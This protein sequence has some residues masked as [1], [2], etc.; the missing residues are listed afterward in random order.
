[1]S[2]MLLQKLLSRTGKQI[3]QESLEALYLKTGLDAT[4]PIAIRG[5]IT[6]RC[7]YRCRYCNFWRQESY[8]EEMTIEEWQNALLSLKSFIGSY[9]IQFSGGEPFIKPGFVDLLEFCHREKIGWGVIT[10]GSAFNRRTVER[11]VAAGPTNIDISVDA[12]TPDIHDFVRGVPG[13]LDRITR[14]IELLRSQRQQQDLDFPIRLKPTV[15]RLNFR[16]L[17]QLVEWAQQVGASTIDFSPVRTLLH[18]SEI[19]TELWLN[20]RKDIETLR[21]VVETLV[22]MKQQGAPIETSTGKLRGLPDH[23]AGNSVYHGVSP[24]R[25][26][27][28]QYCIRPTGDVR[29]CWFYPTIGNVKTQE[30]KEI[31]YSH[32]TQELRSQMVSCTKFGSVACANS[33]LTHRSFSQEV[34]RG[35][36]M[37]KRARV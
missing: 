6:E 18:P 30:A 15:H 10:N 5:Q 17:P 36:L 11:V 31:W 21:D 32:T 20:D 1:M 9:I 25:V 28:R 26:G 14:A 35:L 12:A 33:C 7:N 16:Y 13:S 27:L 2:S 8:P 23:F 37:L 34:K 29:V 4:R 24:C 19:E 22:T 3:V